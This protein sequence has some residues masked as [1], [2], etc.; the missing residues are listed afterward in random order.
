M[1][2]Q[3]TSL[4]GDESHGRLPSDSGLKFIS[5]PTMANRKDAPDTTHT[6]SGVLTLLWATQLSSQILD[7][8][9]NRWSWVETPDG[10]TL[11]NVADTLQRES[12]GRFKSC[13]HRVT[14]PKGF[15]GPRHF[16]SYYLRPGLVAEDGLVH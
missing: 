15:C 4:L 6:D 13:T 12:D 10:H 7:P 1:E 11:V 5:S 9:T 8:L 16:L 2:M 14:Q 3:S